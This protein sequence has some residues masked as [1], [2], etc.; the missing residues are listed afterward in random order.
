MIYD[1]INQVILHFK[2]TN[3][4]V[5]EMPLLFEHLE[6]MK[7]LYKEKKILL[8]ADKYYGSAELF[9]YCEKYGYYYTVKAKP[10]FFKHERI[11]HKEEIDFQIGRKI[12]RNWIKRM[13]YEEVKE[14]TK[15][16]SILHL[17]IVK[18]R[19]QYTDKK[20]NEIQKEADYFTNL[21]RTEFDDKEITVMYKKRWQIETAYD[22][23]K[24]QM[25]IEQFNTYNPIGIKNGIMG[26]VIFFNIQKMIYQEAAKRI[27]KEASKSNYKYQPNNKNIINLVRSES[28]IK[29]FK[30]VRKL[31]HQIV[32]IVRS[33]VK[34][35]I[36]IRSD[37]HYKRW[38]K[39]Y[40]TIP[41]IRHRI[42]GRR[43]PPVAITKAGILSIDH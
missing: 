35:K 40:K 3:Y 42:D 34:E 28:F 10:N 37:R 15:E 41:Q 32:A 12:D 19:Y 2:T 31:K 8:L 36:P 30:S 7:D 9:K 11:E 39:H 5:S 23:L 17:R 16:H 13:K 21:S 25:D 33:A 6:E 24:N 43:N 1:V 4:K 27:E 38:R 18:S 26:K 22:I 29:A 14:Y 20:G